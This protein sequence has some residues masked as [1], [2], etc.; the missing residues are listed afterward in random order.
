MSGREPHLHLYG[1]GLATTGSNGFA[2]FPALKKHCIECNAFSKLESSR[3]V[4]EPANS[5]ERCMHVLV[6]GGIYFLTYNGFW[7]NMDANLEIELHVLIKR[8][9]IMVVL[10]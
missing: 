4:L 1:L 10:L 3:T 6:A 5:T 2:S 9:L 7:F 8:V